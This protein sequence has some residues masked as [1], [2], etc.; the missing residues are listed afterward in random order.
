MYRLSILK[1]VLLPD[2]FVS[3]VRQKSGIPIEE[4]K[5]EINKLI[6]V[7]QNFKI[8]ASYGIMTTLSF[9]SCLQEK[10]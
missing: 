5:Y 10:R 3:N 2:C 1:A 6:L 7:L 4:N 8:S 9:L